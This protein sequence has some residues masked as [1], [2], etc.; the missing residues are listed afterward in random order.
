MR[1]AHIRR[2]FQILILILLISAIAEAKP[3]VVYSKGR[4]S[5][6]AYNQPL[7]S[8][9]YSMSQVTGIK[10][11]VSKKLEAELVNINISNRSVKDVLQMV[12][13][14]FSY[15][16]V[17]TKKDGSWKISTVT[18]FPRSGKKGNLIPTF[19]GTDRAV[20]LKNRL[21]KYPIQIVTYGTIPKNG[22]IL[23]PARM[24]IKK[25]MRKE[26]LYGKGVPASILNLQVSFEESEMRMFKDL[27]MLKCKIDSTKDPERKKS[28][29]MVYAEKTRHFY[30]LKKA[31][32]NKIEA[33]KRIYESRK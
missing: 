16:T 24:M 2:Y 10:F 6:K 28:L 20:L 4:L 32:F 1:S 15:A 13:K 14:N 3:V 29:S 17:Y 26:A 23:V 33:L 9:L 18:V 22:G 11:Y 5:I 7:I 21:M 30:M 12:L 19:A 27:I 8:V 25:T 31:H